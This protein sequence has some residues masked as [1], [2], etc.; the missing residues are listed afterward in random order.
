MYKYIWD[1]IRNIFR[2]FDQSE[3]NFLNQ[4]ITL[5]NKVEKQKARK[6]EVEAELQQIK[7]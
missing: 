7:Y 3:K 4:Y 5:M 1:G 6:R 2:P